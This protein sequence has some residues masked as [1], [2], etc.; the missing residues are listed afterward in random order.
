VYQEELVERYGAVRAGQARNKAEA[1]LIMSEGRK[2]GV[3]ARLVMP[4][5][6]DHAQ[7]KLRAVAERVLH[8]W[9]DGQ[10]ARTT[11]LVFCD[12]GVNPTAWGF[13]AYAA[14]TELLVEGGMPRHEIARI[15]QAKTA[16]A[17][18]RLCLQVQQGQVRVLLGS[19]EKLGTGT[20]VQERLV[21]L[22]HVD[23]P[24][25]P[26]EI[27]QRQG[28]LLRQGN[29]HR[30]WGQPVHIY[31]YGTAGSVEA[32]FW[33]ILQTKAHFIHQFLS[34][35]TCARTAEDIGEQELTFAQM[36]A[37]VSGNPALRVLAE[38]EAE[39]RRLALLAKHHADARF[40]A[41]RRLRALPE[42]QTRQQLLRDQ[43]RADSRALAAW[44]AV[45]GP[46]SV[47]EQVLT[48]E[49]L[50][51]PASCMAL[52][53]AEARRLLDPVLEPVVG[54]KLSHTVRL[55]TYKGLPWGISTSTW[56]GAEVWLQG[57]VTRRVTL[58]RRTRPGVAAL[59][60]LKE[61]ERD[62][63]VRVAQAQHHL[64]RLVQEAHTAQAQVNSVAPQQTYAAALDDY[65]QQLETSLSAGGDATLQPGL[66]R[67]I[68]AL[69]ESQR[70]QGGG[71]VAR[72][73]TAPVPMAEAVT[74]R[75]LAALEAQDA[76]EAAA[77]D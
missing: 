43:L 45:Q 58:G 10:A 21:A 70:A 1:I 54:L 17:R 74:T 35:A 26:N 57:H 39:L 65:R 23:V 73:E 27:N 75:I 49:G 50:L 13:S 20:N 66:M 37:I 24:L 42:E 16:L 63:P 9:H 32:T 52:S 69:R 64:E 18:H 8:H 31:C 15:D 5:A 34:G 19:T 6:V 33:Q 71:G 59:H 46:R 60:A 51:A 67:A 53:E 4:T 48:V 72:T 77:A 38:T 30:A 36:K 29:L 44:D 22:H 7:S 11:Q 55:G 68:E 28:R 76:D 12:V 47:T 41:Q 62:T 25:L 2:L 61:L 14:L 40:E 3:D 56:M